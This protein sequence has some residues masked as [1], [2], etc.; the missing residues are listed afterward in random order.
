[1]VVEIVGYEN[2]GLS[3]SIEMIEQQCTRTTSSHGGPLA[4]FPPIGSQIDA[5]IEQIHS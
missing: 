1:M 5:V 2:A 4:L 3:A